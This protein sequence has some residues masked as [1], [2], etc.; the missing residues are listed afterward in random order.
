MRRLLPN[1]TPE[2]RGPKYE[3]IE[4]LITVGFLSHSVVVNGVHLSFRSLGPGDTFLLRTRLTGHGGGDWRLWTIASSI[5]MVD[6]FL[7]IN[8]P[9][10][11][12]FILQILRKLPKAA[13]EILF[14]IVSGLFIRQNKAL[15]GVEAYC[16][17]G[18]SRYR[19]KSFGGTSPHFHSGIPGQETLGTNYV[20]RMWTFYNQVEDKRISEEAEWEG[21]KLVASTQAYKGMKKVDEHDKQ[22]WQ[23]EQARRQ[24]VQDTF[25]YRTIGLIDKEEEDAIATA[26]KAFEA[27]SA[28]DL[29]H[30]MFLWVSGQEDEH[31]RIVS[32]YKREVIARH[33]AQ[34]A[35]RERRAA[36][37]RR[38]LDEESKTRM[39]PT[40]LVGYTQDQLANILQDR[41]PGG[42]RVVQV[43]GGREDIDYTKYLDGGADTDGLTVTPDGR[44]V[45]AEKRDLTEEVARHQVS[46]NLRREED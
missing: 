2:Q 8:E 22:A 13:H 26:N 37:Y 38:R 46:I 25:F 32:E 9:Q 17:E 18:T 43:E 11:A 29:E 28:E 15:D 36:E 7:V 35:E 45:Q 31:D 3:D 44:V 4:S 30:E 23:K 20:Q 39:Y 14:S 24:L 34:K 6:G 19:W 40:V 10:A 42:V 41:R 16:Y 21:F 27:K 5:W 33:E 1:T 12:P